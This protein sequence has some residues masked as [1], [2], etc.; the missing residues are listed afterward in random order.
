AEIL[1]G[2]SGKDTMHGDFLAGPRYAE[3]P[4]A[5][6]IG[7]DD[8]L[9]GGSGEEEL[10]GGGGN[11]E[12]WGG[13]DSDRLEGQDGSDTLYGGSGIDVLVLDVDASYSVRTGETFNGHF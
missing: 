5:A 4:K 11:D 8:K 1:F 13:P 6:L 3:H 10:L 2:D 12:L 9:F 7:G